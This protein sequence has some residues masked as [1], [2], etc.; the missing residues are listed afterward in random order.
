ESRKK[1][2]VLS[3][4]FIDLIILNTVIPLQFAYAQKRGELI[5]ENL[6]DF[7]KE[8]APEKN[9]I[10]DKFASFGLT[11]KSAFD[12]QVL[13]QLKN[14]YCNQKAC[15]KCAVGIELLKNK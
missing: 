4:A 3:K 12:T 15:L 14:E 1:P 11:S 5:F 7:M 10:I 8:A 13:L 2:K 6:I 9:S